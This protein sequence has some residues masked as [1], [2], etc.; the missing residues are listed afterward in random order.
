MDAVIVRRRRADR[1]A[2]LRARTDDEAFT[3]L[4]AWDVDL[5]NGFQASVIVG[6]EDIS[7]VRGD[8]HWRWHVSV[9][10]KDR[11]PSWEEFSAIVHNMRPGV[12]FAMALPPR[13]WWI[14]IHEHCLHAWEIFDPPLEDQWR[15]ERRGDKPS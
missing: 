8:P 12:V 11:I 1:E 3:H 10:G 7:P 13:S 6:H 5:P 9:A 2:A 4:E 15:A 14:N